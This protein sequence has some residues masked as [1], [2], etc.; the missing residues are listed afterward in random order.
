MSLSL[1]GCSFSWRQ[2]KQTRQIYTLHPLLLENPKFPA[3]PLVACRCVSFLSF[4]VF[5]LLP[6]TVSV[7]DTFRS[8]V[9]LIALFR[10]PAIHVNTMAFRDRSRTQLA[11]RDRVK[12]RKK[13]RKKVSEKEW[14]WKQKEIFELR[15][16]FIPVFPL[17]YMQGHFV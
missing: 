15:T 1:F 16:R 10:L 17:F 14:V 6:S 2:L 11:D 8:T 9:L 5:L 12:E 7:P 3:R 4:F 13:E